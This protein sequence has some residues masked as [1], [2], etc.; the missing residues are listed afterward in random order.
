MIQLL[1]N[2]GS[3]TTINR[4]KFSLENW[5]EFKKKDSQNI[6]DHFECVYFKYIG[7]KKLSKKT[8]KE[9]IEKRCIKE[10]KPFANSEISE[11]HHNSNTSQFNEVSIKYYLNN[12]LNI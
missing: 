5:N 7:N 10:F 4:L 8:Y 1:T 12:E 6:L 9:Q 3:N 2:E 11:T